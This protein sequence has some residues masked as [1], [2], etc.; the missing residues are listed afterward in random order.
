MLDGAA[1]AIG[2]FPRLVS[3]GYGYGITDVQIHVLRGEKAKAL[4]ALRKAEA[5]GWR[6]LWK[7]LPN[8]T[9]WAGR[10]KVDTRYSLSSLRLWAARAAAKRT[11]SA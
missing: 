10:R 9:T 6:G 8:H 2:N 5:S 1:Q 7:R 11:F 4:A 3:G